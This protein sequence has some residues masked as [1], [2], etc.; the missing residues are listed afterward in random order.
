M[1]T[2]PLALLS[3]AEIPRD[4]LT[5]FLRKAGV[6]PVKSAHR[7]FDYHLKRGNA[8]LW[9]DLDDPENY[10]DPEA[11]AQIERKLEGTP[12]TRV[13]LHLSQ[14]PDSEHLAMEFAIAFAKQWPSVID[15]LSGYAWRVYSAQEVEALLRQ[16]KG[17]YEDEQAMPRQKDPNEDQVFIPRKHEK[18]LPPEA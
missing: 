18:H 5:N 2:T 11:D 13:M 12:R 16:G 10:A 14:E 17:L 1:G 15:N 9:I 7:I 8:S 4:Q 3:S 6:E